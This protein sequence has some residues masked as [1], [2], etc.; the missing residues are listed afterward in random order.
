MNGQSH[1]TKP[2]GELDGDRKLSAAMKFLQKTPFSNWERSPHDQLAWCI[3]YHRRQLRL[4]RN[5][6]TVL[7]RHPTLGAT[8][9]ALA[10]EWP[11]IKFELRHEDI[12][13]RLSKRRA[14]NKA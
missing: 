14:E 10:A 11:C 3:S 9:T 6:Q 12:P 1:P 5:I 8:L 2:E 7:L 4:L 13:E